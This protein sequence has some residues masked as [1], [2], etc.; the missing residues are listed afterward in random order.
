MTKQQTTR[1]TESLRDTFGFRKTSERGRVPA[2]LALSV[3]ALLVGAT[4]LDAQNATRD[5]PAD[6]TPGESFQVTINASPGSGASVY[7]VEEAIPDGWTASNPSD[8]GALE[9]QNVK[10]GPFFDTQT[11]NLTYTVTPASGATS[12]T[13]DGVISVDG[14]NHDIGGDSTITAGDGGG[15][16][17]DPEPGPT[18]TQHP[19]N[20]N[21]QLGETATFN[22]VATGTGDLSYQWRRNGTAIEGATDATLTI[23]DVTEAHAGSYTVAVTD[24]EGTTV[25]NA[26]TLTVGDDDGG[27]G[28]PG[29]GTGDINISSAELGLPGIWDLTGTYVQ[30]VRVNNGELTMTYNLTHDARGR[31]TGDGTAHFERDHDDLEIT[32]PINVRGSI[33]TGRD[34][35]RLNLRGLAN[36]TATIDGRPERF[37]FRVDSTLELDE[38]NRV[39]SG[40]TNVQGQLPDERHSIRNRDVTIDI[41]EG[42]SGDWT[43]AINPGAD[44]RTTGTATMN[45]AGRETPLEFQVTGRERG[46]LTVYR[47]IGTGTARGARA[48]VTVD[49]QNQLRAITGS[50]LRQV[51]NHTAN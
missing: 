32:A 21:V 44:P 25:S 19:Q 22:V 11:R 6:F 35:Q 20:R 26:A 2:L 14:T 9:G 50:I 10:W 42:I 33:R 28:G 36:G 48:N 24:D 51:L 31:L 18:I 46:G 37:N 41:P 29:T 17:V 16:G 43:L 45:L 23:T 4:S 49:A 40:T 39:L 8:N 47:L 15:G 34:L 12:G 7:A 38:Q 30:T 5:L 3:C 1:W 27:T 13:F